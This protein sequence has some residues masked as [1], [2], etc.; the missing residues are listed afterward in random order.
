MKDKIIEKTLNTTDNIDALLK[1]ST[2]DEFIEYIVFSHSIN[3]VISTVVL[4]VTFF[5]ALKFLKRS[6][7]L[8]LVDPDGDGF[9]GNFVVAFFFFVFSIIS[10][11]F[12]VK[13][14]KIIKH[15]QISPKTLDISLQEN[16]RI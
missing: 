2:T 16:C 13:N 5:I 4:I 15:A 6:K 10:F 11:S 1:D 9:V 12:L 7:T 8:F 14:Y 3:V